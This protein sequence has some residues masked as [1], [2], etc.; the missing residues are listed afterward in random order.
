MI[1][2]PVRGRA[3]L[4]ESLAAAGKI[5]TRFGLAWLKSFLAASLAALGLLSSA[6]AECQEAIG[7]AQTGG[8]R[9]IEA[10]ARQTFGEIVMKQSPSDLDV[11]QREL[12]E[13]LRLHREISALPQFARSTVSYARMLQARGMRTEAERELAEARSRFQRLG[14]GWDLD[15]AKLPE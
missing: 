1:G 6:R 5:G 3:L 15:R 9:W 4:E 10:I 14:M 8:D 12:E 2:D 11:A 13:S 7:L